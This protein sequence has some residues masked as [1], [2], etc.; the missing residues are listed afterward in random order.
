MEL[1]AGE[2]ARAAWLAQQAEVVARATG[3]VP[4]PYFPLMAAA[5]AGRYREAVQ[6]I[7]AAMG[8]T[9]P[10]DTQRL[11]T[12]GWAAAVLHNGLSRYR[13]ALAAAER[14]SAYLGEPGLAV[15][16]LAELLEAAARAGQPGRAT[17]ALDRLSEATCAAG[18]DWAL[19]IQGRCRAL[20]SEGEAA[21]RGYVEAIGRL[22]RT[23]VRVELARAY[24]LYGEWLRRENRRVDAREQLRAAYEMLAVMGIGGF[25]ERARLELM[26]TGET[27]RKRGA[28][29]AVELTA[30]E[31]RIVRLAID[32]HT[33]PEISVQLFLS[34][35]TVEWHLRKVF[36]KLGIRSR[37]E[38]TIALN[39]FEQAGLPTRPGLSRQLT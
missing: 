14:A 31:I 36:T 27:V 2:P 1:L 7:A 17:A 22:S 5:W 8:T 21:E 19:G 30:Q 39:E 11:T 18:T 34:P 10:G 4:E 28:D 35:R 13:E 38:L 29:T 3:R 6:L 16:S 25:A 26:A 15:W 32:G 24:L 23:R 37:K 20:L 9:A 12:A 33:N